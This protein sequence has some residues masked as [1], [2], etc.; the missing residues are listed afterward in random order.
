M[1]LIIA[2]SHQVRRTVQA[3]GQKDRA[4]TLLYSFPNSKWDN[5]RN[6]MGGTPPTTTSPPTTTTPPSGCGGVA[7]WSPGVNINDSHI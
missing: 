6:N 1:S 5:I 3:V 2:E 4:M 7:A